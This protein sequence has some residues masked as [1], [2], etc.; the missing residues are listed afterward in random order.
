MSFS[1]PSFTA[2]RAFSAFERHVALQLFS[3]GWRYFDTYW[4][5][6]DR[7]LEVSVPLIYGT[8]R[9]REAGAAAVILLKVS[10]WRR[11]EVKLILHHVTQ[12]VLLIWSLSLVHYS[13]NGWFTAS[14]RWPGKSSSRERDG[15]GEAVPGRTTSHGWVP[16]GVNL[17]AGNHWRSNRF[18][19]GIESR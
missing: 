5:P 8:L 1:T 2:V 17:T 10:L 18:I 19:T 9:R 15:G 4:T 3:T 6:F 16:P 13:C 7:R 11:Q 12:S 14:V